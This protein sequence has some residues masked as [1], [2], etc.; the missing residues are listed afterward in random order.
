MG[1]QLTTMDEM[2]ILEFPTHSVLGLTSND[3]SMAYCGQLESGF[4]TTTCPRLS[5]S[6]IS[7]KTLRHK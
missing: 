5:G 4:A 7:I 1:P 3:A 6:Y 2:K